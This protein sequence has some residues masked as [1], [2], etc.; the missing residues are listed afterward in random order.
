MFAVKL[1]PAFDPGT[2][3]LRI[4]MEAE[5]L[6]PDIRYTLD[7][8]EPAAES[9]AYAGPLD[10][11]KSAVIKAGVFA[12]GRLRGPVTETAFLV[13]PALGRTPILQ[14]P[15]RERYAAGGPGGLV[16]GLKG[17]ASHTD[18][19]WQGFEGDD[20]V[21]TIDLGK[22]KKIREVEI[23]F[24]QNTAS[25]IFFPRSVEVAVS[26]DGTDFHVAASVAFPVRD[27]AGGALTETVRLGIENARARFVRVT[28][29]S[30]KACPEG[31]AGAGEKA[32]L[33]S[34]EIVIR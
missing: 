25:W 27:E 29:A 3:R 21:A 4:G 11:S 13:H 1:A 10:L 20:M 12:G 30:I 23:G 33:F 31:H 15:Y 28:A 7:G 2:K 22:R 16:D 5:S 6:R 17:G 32:W 18:G 14:F 34:D 9:K 19:R 8:S 26:D 24:L